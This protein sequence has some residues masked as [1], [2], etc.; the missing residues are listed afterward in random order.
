MAINSIYIL[1]FLLLLFVAYYTVCP[2]KYRWVVLLFGSVFFYVTACAASPVYILVTGIVIWAAGICVERCEVRLVRY[3]EECREIAKVQQK[4]AEARCKKQKK[5]IV[6]TAILINLGILTVL[7]YGGLLGGM[8]NGMFVFTGRSL[9]APQFLVPL[10][11]SY[12]TL[13]SIGYL[14]DIYKGKTK[15]QRNFLKV[16][17]FLSFFPQ[18]T[19]GPLSRYRQLGGQLYEGHAYDYHN[20]S[21]GCQRMLWGFF[22]KMVIAE[23]MRPMMQA[24]F[25]NYESYGGVT[26]FLGCIYMTVWMYADFSGY[27][28]IVS[29]TAEIFGIRLEENFRRPFFAES[30]AE[31]WRRWHITLSSWFR[32]YMFYPLAVSSPAVKFGK[33]GRKW[34]G[35][36]IGKL[37]PS[38]FALS[39]VWTATGLWHDASVKYVLW[40]VA[41]GAVIMGAM[42]V[43]PAFTG[44]KKFLHI[45]QESKG[46]RVFSKFRT[47]LLV[48][49][50]KIFP[51]ASSGQA[52]LGMT[53]K[54]VLD[55]R[56]P[57]SFEEVFPGMP[58]EEVVILA[59]SLALFFFV[60]LFEEKRRL[61]ESLASRPFGV[62][63]LS[64]AFLL[65]AILCLGKFGIDMTGGFAYAQ[66]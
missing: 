63:W 16:M 44:A 55:L 29:G 61:R 43:E 18:I 1:P 34:F 40:G 52:A 24:I 2:V 60:D 56:L 65:A 50:L 57:G 51:G 27:M 31:Y 64:Y 62:R 23:R 22:K 45:R 26:C 6:T 38:L 4:Q 7:K 53:K 54:F 3:R 32:D 25:D 35:A 41:N 33:L 37:F 10:G 42:V 48:S 15:V 11:I 17:L 39:F 13:I 19:Q 58:V 49:A 46:W 12:Y 28:D 30:L 36:R 9:P 21:F 59:M 47:F 14:I 66:Y 5:R 20:L 8:L